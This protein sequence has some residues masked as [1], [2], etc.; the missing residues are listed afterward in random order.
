MRLRILPTIRHKYLDTVVHTGLS[1]L[2]GLIRQF[3]IVL[4]CNN[5]N[6]PFALVPRLGAAKVA[7]NVDGLEWE[8]GKWSIHIRLIH[9]TTTGDLGASYESHSTIVFVDAIWTLVV[10]L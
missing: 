3:E 6:A 4:I 9:T 7:L 8:R 10:Q 5:A 2:D 1:V